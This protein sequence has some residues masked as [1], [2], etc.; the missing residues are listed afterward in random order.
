MRGAK[1][2]ARRKIYIH[3][4]Y[5]PKGGWDWGE[6]RSSSN[7]MVTFDPGDC[8]ISELHIPPEIDHEHEVIIDNYHA[9]E[10]IPEEYYDNIM[11]LS[12][13]LKRYPEYLHYIVID[14]AI[15]EDYLRHYLKQFGRMVKGSII[16]KVYTR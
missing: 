10:N 5:G 16:E 2:K 8:E 3:V 6:K 9:N 14:D 13:T 1:K 15:Y 7:E 11:Y 4:F 12:D